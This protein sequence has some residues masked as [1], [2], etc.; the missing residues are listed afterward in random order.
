MLSALYSEL[1]MEP[2]IVA[3]P[4][5]DYYIYRAERGENRS[6]KLVLLRIEFIVPQ[7]GLNLC[8]GML[9]TEQSSLN[10]PF[11][12]LRT[13]FDKSQRKRGNQTKKVYK[14]N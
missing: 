14:T 2:T 10:G 1:K 4:V 7:I 13:E 3:H 9:N 11:G 5:F 12:S 6:T 8:S